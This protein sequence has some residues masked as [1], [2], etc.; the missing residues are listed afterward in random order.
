MPEKTGVFSVPKASKLATYGLV[1]D[2]VILE[3]DG[4]TIKSDRQL[5][6]M[7]DRLKRGSHIAKVRRGQTEKTVEFSN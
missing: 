6:T 4:N 1:V 7:F 3:I 5:V 2:D